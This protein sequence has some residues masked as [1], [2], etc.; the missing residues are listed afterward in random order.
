MFPARFNTG[1]AFLK[2]ISYDLQEDDWK[3]VGSVPT[4]FN[5]RLVHADDN[6]I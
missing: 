3:W 6:S 5:M 1:K 4:K 2:N